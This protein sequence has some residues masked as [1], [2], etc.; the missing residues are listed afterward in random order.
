M[1]YWSVWSNTVVTDW[2]VIDLV[3]LQLQSQLA[4]RRSRPQGQIVECLAKCDEVKE[5]PHIHNFK[6]FSTYFSVPV[7][8]LIPWLFPS[9]YLL[10]T[11]SLPFFPCP[12]SHWGKIVALAPL[13]WA[14]AL[15]NITGGLNQGLCR[16]TA[17][18]IYGMFRN[19]FS[20]VFITFLELTV[21]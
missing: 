15:T 8:F 20:Y 12:P 19:C 13:F 5:H 7:T 17:L 16:H 6:H 14:L 11:G 1:T 4:H 10:V 2:L 3:R 18:T 21:Y 9:D